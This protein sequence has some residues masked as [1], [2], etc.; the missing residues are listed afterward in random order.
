MKTTLPEKLP[1]SRSDEKREP[2]SITKVNTMTK[3]NHSITFDPD[4]DRCEQS[5]KAACDVN[6]IMSKFQKTGVIDHLRKHGGQY[7]DVPSTDFREAMEVITTAESMFAELPSQ[8]RKRFNNDPAEFL[9]FVQD[10]ENQNDLHVLGLLDPNYEPKSAAPQSITG[11]S[12]GSEATSNGEGDSD[13]SASGGGETATK[14]G[15]ET[16]ASPPE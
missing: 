3:R 10:P 15:S 12:K 16:K 7:A 1:L 2:A 9:E 11:E 5:H 14:T 8:A 13:A 4:E 6:N